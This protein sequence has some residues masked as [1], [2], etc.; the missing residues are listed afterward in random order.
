MK[1]T[2]DKDEMFRTMKTIKNKDKRKEFREE[3]EGE[4]DEEKKK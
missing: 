4:H 2:A 1:E 3:K